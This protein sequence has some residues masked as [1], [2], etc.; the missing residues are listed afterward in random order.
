M[1]KHLFS[2]YFILILSVCPGGPASHADEAQIKLLP[3]PGDAL[4][5]EDGYIVWG[6]DM[7]Q[8][9]DGTCHLFYCRWKGKLQRDWYMQSEIVHATADSPLGPYQPQQVVLG[10][11]KDGAGIWD[12]LASYNPTVCRFGDKYYLYYTGSNG[13]NRARKVGDNILAQRI[14]VAVADHPAGPWQR[15][16]TPL[17]DLSQD[18]MDSGM[19]CN[20]T[21]TRGPDGRFV[22]IYKCAEPTGKGIYLTVAFADSPTGPFKKSGRKILSHPTSEFA[23]EDPF[24]WWQD[25]KFHCVVD[26]QHGDFSGAKG[27]ILFES[28]DALDWKKSDP[29][30]LSR[31]QIP[32]DNGQVEETTHLE[33]PQ[34]WFDNGV[35]SVLFVAVAQ[36]DR[37]FNL[38]VPLEFIEIGTGK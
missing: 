23:V 17:I 37:Y 6:A 26:D 18:G 34:I 13:S 32:W 8:A 38:H 28:Q 30:V 25:G 5:S 2:L 33:R 1:S 27:L 29:F 24:L 9:E 19:C 21:V 4:L 12:G 7:V 3:V 31:C 22:M 36:G 10:P 11:R 16:D 14:G 35:P 15:M 20:P